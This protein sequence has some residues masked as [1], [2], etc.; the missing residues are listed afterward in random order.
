M[1][2]RVQLQSLRLKWKDS[3]TF[4]TFE[5]PYALPLRDLLRT[6]TEHL[7]EHWAGSGPSPQPTVDDMHGGVRK[8]KLT[9]SEDQPVGE[10]LSSPVARIA[11]TSSKN[12]VLPAASESTLTER[13]E[14]IVIDNGA[15]ALV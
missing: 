4:A 9:G 7:A 13:P 10:F 14:A 1:A 6:A 8:F 11:V 5:V 2:L 15:T 12:L 3:T